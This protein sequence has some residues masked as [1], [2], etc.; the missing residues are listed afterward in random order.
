M[1][2]ARGAQPAGC[3][4][5]TPCYRHISLQFDGARDEPIGAPIERRSPGDRNE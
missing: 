1:V 4:T 5:F 2:V 3:H